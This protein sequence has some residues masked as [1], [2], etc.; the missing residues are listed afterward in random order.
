MDFLNVSVFLV[1]ST[2]P[3]NPNTSS[4][5]SQPI[6]VSSVNMT[7][8][9]SAMV[10]CWWARA[11][12]LRLPRFRWFSEKLL[13]GLLEWRPPWCNLLCTVWS[14]I[15]IPVARVKSYPICLAVDVGGICKSTV[16]GNDPALVLSYEERPLPGLLFAFPVSLYFL[17][18]L[19]TP[20]W[21]TFN[22]SATSCC[23][24]PAESK[25]TIW[26]LS[27]GCNQLRPLCLYVACP[28][29]AEHK[30]NEAGVDIG[31]FVACVMF[32]CLGNTK[33]ASSKHCLEYGSCMDNE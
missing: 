3:P 13:I 20:L 18:T 16:G 14:E 27:N 12:F 28:C 17:H 5:R 21:V 4:V 30:V 33:H 24:W 31:L 29:T 6:L 25:A 9:H 15:L 19:D 23:V 22:R 10:Q 7:F 8:L 2:T 11:Q 32:T 26:T 1:S